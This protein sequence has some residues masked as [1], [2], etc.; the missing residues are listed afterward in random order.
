LF[1]PLF[2]SLYVDTTPPRVT[3][4]ARAR[5]RAPSPPRVTKRT[6]IPRVGGREADTGIQQRRESLTCEINC[7]KEDQIS[8][9]AVIVI[10]DTEEPDVERQRSRPG[11]LEEREWSLRFFG[12]LSTRQLGQFHLVFHFSLSR[13]AFYPLRD[14]LNNFIPR[15]FM[16][17]KASCG[18]PRYAQINY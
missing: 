18:F 3:A 6:Q 10:T 5:A 1:P 14:L 15:I 12:F 8:A 17:W 11:T 9:R 7:G 4:C 2:R 16:H 13:G